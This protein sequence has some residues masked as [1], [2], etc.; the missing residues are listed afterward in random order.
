M[1]NNKYRLLVF[2]DDAGNYSEGDTSITNLFIDTGLLVVS[3]KG[4]IADCKS[5]RV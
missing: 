2:F 1:N 5:P 3:T 4:K